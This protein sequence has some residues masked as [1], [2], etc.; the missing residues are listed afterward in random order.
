MKL[1]CLTVLVIGRAVGIDPSCVTVDHVQLCHGLPTYAEIGELMSTEYRFYSNATEFY[2][3]LPTHKCATDQRA[4]RLLI[5]RIVLG[6]I[7]SRLKD[8]QNALKFKMPACSD[9]P[10][11]T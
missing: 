11:S 7:A 10:E 9:A 8:R 3:Y 2:V 4:A 5:D 6:L 1:F